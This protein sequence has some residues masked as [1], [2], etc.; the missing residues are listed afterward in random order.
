IEQHRWTQLDPPPPARQGGWGE[1]PGRKGEPNAQAEDEVGRKKALQGHRLRKGAFRPIGQAPRHDQADYQADPR[2]SRHQG[3]VQD[4]RRPDQEILVA[5][6]LTVA[7]TPPPY[8]PP[9]AWKGRERAV[10]DARL[11]R[12]E[13]RQ[14]FEGDP[15]WPASNGRHRTCQ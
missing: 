10:A 1:G 12:Q 14:D 3:A 11:P 4:R 8:P 13:I 7:P 6:Q 5:E 9:R 2:A 15:P